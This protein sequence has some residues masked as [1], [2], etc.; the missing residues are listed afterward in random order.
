MNYGLSNDPSSSFFHNQ[1][2]TTPGALIRDRDMFHLPDEYIVWAITISIL[3]IQIF[4][5][6]EDILYRHQCSFGTTFGLMLLS[7]I[8]GMEIDEES[9]LHEMKTNLFGI[10]PK[11]TKWDD[12]NIPY[13]QHLSSSLAEPQISQ[14]AG[15][16]VKDEKHTKFWRRIFRKPKLK[17]TIFKSVS[18]SLAKGKRGGETYTSKNSEFMKNLASRFGHASKKSKT[19]LTKKKSNKSTKQSTDRKDMEVQAGDLPLSLSRQDSQASTRSTISMGAK[20]RSDAMA[21]DLLQEVVQPLCQ[22]RG[23]DLFRTE[24]PDPDMLTHPFLLQ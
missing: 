1:E 15:G 18:T 7:F 20:D 16:K 8:A 13:F 17:K 21:V 24:D 9:L 3:V 23:L 2:E 19:S 12:T 6:W 11:E 4:D 14:R 5:S 22:V 10:K